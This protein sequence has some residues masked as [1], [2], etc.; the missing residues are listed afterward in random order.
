MNAA[1][2]T[3]ETEKVR[4]AL[5][6][7]TSGFPLI[8]GRPQQHQLEDREAKQ[9]VR[10]FTAAAITGFGALVVA[11]SAH[12]E[13]RTNDA[14]TG[15]DK[16]LH[17]AA[18]A[19]VGSSVTVVTGRP[20]YGFIAGTAVGAL[21]ELSDSRHPGAHDCSLQDLLMTS[22][23]AAVGSYTGGVFLTYYRGRTGV[24]IRKEF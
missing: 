6:T 10:R 17:A 20:L 8:D 21:K 12:A 5:A 16:T 11:A 23:G 9:R 14:W 19:L 13:L 22:A 4:A 7:R 24:A 3:S 2:V 15:P 18:G 1:H